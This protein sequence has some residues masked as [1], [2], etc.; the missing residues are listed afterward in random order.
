MGAR[1]NEHAELLLQSL[2][3]SYDQLV[4]NLT[5]NV[6]TDYLNFDDIAA[7]I[8]EEE[9]QRKN[10]EDKLGSSQKVEAFVSVSPS[11]NTLYPDFIFDIYNMRHCF[12]IY[13]SCA[14]MI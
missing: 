4:I 14:C 3:D 12:I 2:L 11:P 9:N 7:A 10:K 8:L 1:Q 5:N 13:Y 6:L